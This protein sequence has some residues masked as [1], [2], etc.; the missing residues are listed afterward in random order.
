MIRAQ[1]SL[2]YS[3]RKIKRRSWD[4]G[5]NMRC[6]ECS[7]TLDQ[8]PATCF[9]ALWSLFPPPYRIG[10]SVRIIVHAEDSDSAEDSAEDSDSA[11]P[12]A[13]KKHNENQKLGPKYIHIGS[14]TGLRYRSPGRTL[15]K[16]HPARHGRG[17][18]GVVYGK[19]AGL[20]LDGSHVL[21]RAP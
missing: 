6:L 11:L 20:P 3:E 18:R 2:A 4:Q 13:Q 9:S 8:F 7:S 15:T 14:V 16:E 21:R 1:R 17:W 10:L 19:P 12:S 5:K